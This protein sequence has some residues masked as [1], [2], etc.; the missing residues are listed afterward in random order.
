MCGIFGFALAEPV[1]M[2]KVF[3]IL[4]KL[5][6]HQ[7][8]N[9]KRPVG[10]YGAGAATL[11]KNMRFI[12]EKVGK[13][14]ASPARSLSEIF[15]VDETRILVSHVRMPSPEFMETA[16]FRETAQPYVAGCS[17]NLTVVSA[18]NGKVENYMEIRKSLSEAHFFESEKMGLIDSEIIPHL[19]EETL[20]QKN[21][22]AKALE[23]LFSVLQGSSTI[24]LL[25]IQ[26]EKLLLHLVHRGKTRGL[27]VWT[28]DENEIVFCSRKEPLTGE[29]DDILVHGKFKEKYSI[30]CQEEAVLKLTVPLTVR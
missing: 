1:K 8:P 25:Q 23:R 30:G 3:R 26:G 20:T 18:H 9:E 24:S 19:F 21:D 17:S 29:F 22:A 16:E 5:E 2:A 7:Y 28:N 11:G 10:G 14:S 12:C 27:T 15:K 4:R 6:A 13:V